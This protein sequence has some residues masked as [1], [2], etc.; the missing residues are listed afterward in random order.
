M[1]QT[2]TNN[3]V[4]ILSIEHYIN[5]LEFTSLLLFHDNYMLQRYQQRGAY[6]PS[7]MTIDKIIIYAATTTTIHGSFVCSSNIKNNITY[8]TII[9]KD[10]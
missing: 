8:I 5:N 3:K 7:V 2:N 10:L 6:A 1:N 9:S 4:C